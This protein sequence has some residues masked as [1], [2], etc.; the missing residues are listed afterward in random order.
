MPECF[1]DT[2]KGAWYAMNKDE[3]QTAEPGD[4]TLTGTAPT[5]ETP[6]PET[7]ETP[8]TAPAS[9]TTPEA[10]DAS[11]DAH[12]QEIAQLKEAL[13]KANKEAAAHRVKAKELDDLKAQ[14][15][16]E[17]LTEKERLEKKIADLQK[18][19]DEATRL[20]QE[21]RV[22]AEVRMQALQLNFT[23]PADAQRFL[24]YAEIEYGDDGA[25]Q[26]IGDLLKGVLKAKPYLAT[27]PAKHA[28]NPGGATNPPRSQSSTPA[29][30]SWAAISKLTESE[31]AAR[32]DEIA[33]WIAS[34][35]AARRGMR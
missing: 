28:P 27:A 11:A 35:P 30:L 13:K 15:E 20:A 14:A 6:T 3:T 17:K 31:Y 5:G 2:C 8:G 29:A 12:E 34:N 32:H 19:H 1:I 26:N 25:P 4:E 18:A 21:F 33:A 24:D 7:G 23:D 16:A 22:S 9:P 10:A